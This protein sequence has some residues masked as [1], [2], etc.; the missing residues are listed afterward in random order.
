MDGGQ[1]H[2]VVFMDK[3]TEQLYQPQFIWYLNQNN[4]WVLIR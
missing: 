2:P 4:E 1:N 3:I